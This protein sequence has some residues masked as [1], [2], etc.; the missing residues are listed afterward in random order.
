[1]S[2]FCRTNHNEITTKLSIITLKCILSSTM[3]LSYET[4][5]RKIEEWALIRG[6][7]A[8]SRRSLIDDYVFRVG[9]YSRRILFEGRL[10]E[11]LRYYYSPS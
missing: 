8:Y 2:T 7:G 6:G 1:M 9:A 10:I 3:N 11:A 4:S 5:N